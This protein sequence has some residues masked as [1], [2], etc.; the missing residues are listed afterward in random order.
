MPKMT[1]KG[2][3]MQV[4]QGDKKETIKKAPKKTAKNHKNDR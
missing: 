4:K 2:E 3:K 1:K